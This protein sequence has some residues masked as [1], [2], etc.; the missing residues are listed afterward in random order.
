MTTD[1][2]CSTGKPRVIYTKDHFEWLRSAGCIGMRQ[3]RE[4]LTG[5]L[6]ETRTALDEIHGRPVC[7]ARVVWN[8]PH[9]GIRRLLDRGDHFLDNL[10]E[11]S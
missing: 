2:T 7:I 5:T 9:L 6:V 8:R 4:N 3:R 11:V 1:E 10:E